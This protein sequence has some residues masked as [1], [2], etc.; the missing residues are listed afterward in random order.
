MRRLAVVLLAVLLTASLIACA[1]LTPDGS[2]KRWLWSHYSQMMMEW[3]PPTRSFPDGQ[4]GQILVYEFDRGQT[5]VPGSCYY[6][7]SYGRCWYT[8]TRITPN[9][10]TRTF[11]V[12]KNGLIYRYQ[13]KGW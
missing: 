13:W 8:P 2:M 11:W 10:A 4:D 6:R 3:G 12:N 1:S 5:V 9:T 7:D